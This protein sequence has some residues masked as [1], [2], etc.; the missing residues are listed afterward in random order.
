MRRSRGER[1]ISHAQ[2]AAGSNAATWTTPGRG[3]RGARRRCRRGVA[4][5]LVARR[6]TCE[7]C[8]ERHSKTRLLAMEGEAA[9]RRGGVTSTA[10]DTV[11]TEKRRAPHDVTPRGRRL[12]ICF[13]FRR[14]RCRGDARCFCVSWVRPT[15]VKALSVPTTDSTALLCVRSHFSFYASKLRLL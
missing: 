12:R 13:R 6:S 1:G 2:E 3:R 7:Y 9:P 15:P 8:S 5:P 14:E 10:T 4:A 11:P